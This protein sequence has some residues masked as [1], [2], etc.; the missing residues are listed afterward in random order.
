MSR[1]RLRRREKSRRQS[2]PPSNVAAEPPPII[3][4]GTRIERL[5]YTRSQAAAALGI[6]RSTFN[7]RVLPL[8]ETIETGWGTR[9]VP[10]DELQRFVAERRRTAQ[11]ERKPP[12]RTGRRPGLPVEVINRIRAE[13]ADGESLGAIARGLNADDVRTSQGGRQWWPSAVRAVLLEEP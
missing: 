12:G 13:H 4:E 6:S 7:R 3:R 9:L 8:V 1:R 5:A 11:A 10:V 2:P